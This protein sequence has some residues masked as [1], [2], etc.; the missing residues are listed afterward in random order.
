LAP[1]EEWYD[2]DSVNEEPLHRL[3]VPSLPTERLQVSTDTFKQNVLDL[4]RIIMT[5]QATG[6]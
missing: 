3:I 5:T 1:C 2:G 6:D 4:T